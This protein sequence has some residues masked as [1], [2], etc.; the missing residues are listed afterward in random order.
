ME[1]VKTEEQ[2]RDVSMELDGV[3]GELLETSSVLSVCVSVNRQRATRP[4]LLACKKNQII[5]SRVPR[6]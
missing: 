2:G 3:R 4:R 5:V 1:F 6:M